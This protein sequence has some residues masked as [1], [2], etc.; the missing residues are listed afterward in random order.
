MDGIHI[1][2]HDSS[3]FQCLNYSTY[4]R[5]SK[6]DDI[7]YYHDIFLCTDLSQLLTFHFDKR[8]LFVPRSCRGANLNSRDKEEKGIDFLHYYEIASPFKEKTDR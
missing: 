8:L 7:T 1:D 4:V 3:Y 5:S 2:R 6:H